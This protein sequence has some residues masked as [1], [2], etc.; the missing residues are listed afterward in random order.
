MATSLRQSEFVLP[1][2]SDERSLYGIA[3]GLASFFQAKRQCLGRPFQVSGRRLV[4]VYLDALGWDLFQEAGAKVNGTTERGITVFP[5]T[6]A[7]ALSTLMSAQLPGEHGML[8]YMVYNKLLGGIINGIKYSYMGEGGSGTISR[9]LTQAFPV[10]PWL[11]ETE[12]KV[13]ALMSTGSAS[14]ELTRAFLLNRPSQGLTI[15]R[16][17]S[18]SYEMLASLSEALEGDPHDLVYVYH[19]NPDHFGHLYGLNSIHRDLAVLEVRTIVERINRLAEKYKDRY[20]FL[21]ISDH[22]QVTVSRVYLFNNDDQLLEILEVPPYGDSR[23]VWF[24]S[25]MDLKDLLA[26]RYRMT[27]MSREEVISSGLLGRVDPWVRVN[28]MGDYL[29]V[30]TDNITKYHYSYRDDDPALRLRGHHSGLTPQEML[31]PVVYWE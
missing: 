6:T 27:V 20:S 5:S 8:G 25:R 10:R 1:D 2:Y 23:A 12:A 16:S 14:G 7:T 31:I 28:V 11:A 21:L 29:G 30:A 4:L 3:C 26:E 18:S 19:D 17:H 9:P 24:R 22:G 15:I 13:L